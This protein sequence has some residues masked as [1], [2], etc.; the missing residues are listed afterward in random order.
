MRKKLHSQL[1]IYFTFFIFFT[2]L[3]VLILFLFL[4]FLLKKYNLLING[5]SEPIFPILIVMLISLFIGLALSGFIGR[6]I[7][8]PIAKLR[9]SM[10]L[11]AKGDFSIQLEENQKLNDVNQL[12]HDFN[13]MVT[14]LR[15]IESMRHDFVSNVSHEFKTPIATIRGYVQLLQDDSLSSLDRETYLHRMLDGTQQLSYLTDNILRLT[16][17]EN[18]KMGLEYH[19]FRLDEQI[20]EVILFLQPKWEPLEIEFELDLPTTYY[21]GNEELLYQVWLNV[22]ENGIKYN[23][24]NGN[25]KVTLFSTNDDLY[26]SLSDNGIGMSETTI[27]HAFDKFYQNDGSRQSKGNGLGLP[28]VKQIIG[29]HQ[30]MV[31]IESEL[32]VGSE[33]K[34]VLPIKKVR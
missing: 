15:S 5:H 34:I 6:K 1:W 31:E 14:E 16:K 2:I 8:K 24:K 29:L 23:Q 30:G 27:R 25:I 9:E 33:I 22:V 4:I 3:F 28:L 10:G 12:Y 18:Q 32:A 7:L 20:R 21:M 26:I 11:V 17:L 13:V 19:S